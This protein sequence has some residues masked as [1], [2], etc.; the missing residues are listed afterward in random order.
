MNDGFHSQ[1]PVTRSFDVFIDVRLN[2]D[3]AYSPD[4]GDLRRHGAHYVVTAMSSQMDDL[5]LISK[6]RSGNLLSYSLRSYKL[7]NVTILPNN[8]IL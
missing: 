5:L 1:R 3:V 8:T 7:P 6:F 2:N 4:A